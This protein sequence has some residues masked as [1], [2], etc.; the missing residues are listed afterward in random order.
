VNIYRVRFETVGQGALRKYCNADP[1]MYKNVTQTVPNS[2]IP[3]EDW[4]EVTGHETDN[5]WQ[6]YNQL[7]AWDAADKEFIRNVRLEKLVSD[8]EWEPVTEAEART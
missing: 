7:R 1:V 4:H 6:Q 8:P 5:P 2:Q 3:D